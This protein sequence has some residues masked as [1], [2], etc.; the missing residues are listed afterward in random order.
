MEN[1]NQLLLLQ[2]LHYIHL[3]ACFQDNLG[4]PAPEQQNH[5]SKTNLDLLKQETVGG[6]GISLAICK[7]VPRL[8]Y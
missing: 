1:I 5:Y 4:D 7:S 6:S 8:R 3:T 2:L